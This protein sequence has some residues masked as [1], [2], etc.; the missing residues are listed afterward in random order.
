MVDPGESGREV[1]RIPVGC[2]YRRVAAVV[3]GLERSHHHSLGV[4][5]HLGIHSTRN[6]AGSPAIAEAGRGHT[7]DPSIHRT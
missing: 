4:G 2:C 1:H 3:V 6:W 5:D 7:T